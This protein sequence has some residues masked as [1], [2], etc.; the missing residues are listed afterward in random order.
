MQQSDT[1]YDLVNFM[2]ISK[3]EWPATG[4]QIEKLTWFADAI[5]AF[6]ITLLA[7]DI[8]A[9]DISADL[10]ATELP[11]ALLNLTPRIVSFLITFW[12]V[13]S[14]WVA[15][16]RAFSLIVRYDRGL[17]YLN[18]LFLMFIVLVP[19]PSDLV[20]RYPTQFISAILTAAFFAATGLSLSL[21]WRHASSNHRLVKR[22]LDQ[23]SIGRLTLG[24]L[25]SPLVFIFSIPIFYAASIFAP[26]TA[27]FMEFFWLLI[28]PIHSIID[29]RYKE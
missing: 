24:Y 9:P 17:I 11:S 2:P 26:S 1:E 8:R 23:R 5:F 18:L 19:F 6:S 21:I 14:Y 3:E 28:V 22:K 12:V 27:S 16:H 15:Y 29:R 4:L 7:I 13:G 10:L 20:G 25:A